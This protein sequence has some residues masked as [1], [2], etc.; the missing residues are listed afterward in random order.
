PILERTRR[1]PDGAGDGL[2]ARARRSLP[3][4]VG[5]HAGPHALGNPRRSTAR[6]ESGD[7]RA[8]RMNALDSLTSSHASLSHGTGTSR[9][10]GYSEHVRSAVVAIWKPR[11]RLK[12][13]TLSNC[14]ALLAAKRMVGTQSKSNPPL[15]IGSA[16]AVIP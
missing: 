4:C 7:C 15:K 5:E 1:H 16:P 10:T 9:Q 2:P 12:A 3:A 13:S 6:P 8:R 14:H 11:T